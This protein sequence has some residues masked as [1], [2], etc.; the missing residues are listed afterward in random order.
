M[1]KVKKKRGTDTRRLGS[2]P[3]FLYGSFLAD[4]QRKSEVKTRLP[5]YSLAEDLRVIVVGNVFIG[6]IS[7]GMRDIRS[8]TEC[9]LRMYLQSIFTDTYFQHFPKS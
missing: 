2:Y 3:A 9:M 6:S 8:N 5:A 1:D 4:A 7:D